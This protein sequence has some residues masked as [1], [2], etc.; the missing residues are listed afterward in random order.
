MEQIL[1]ELIEEKSAERTQC[2]RSSDRQRVDKHLKTL[3]ELL[4]I[5]ELKSRTNNQLN[6]K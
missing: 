2:Y 1:R 5:Q 4:R 6:L 3:K